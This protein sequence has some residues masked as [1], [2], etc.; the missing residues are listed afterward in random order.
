MPCT[1]RRLAR[2]LW[3]CC[4]VQQRRHT[5]SYVNGTLQHRLRVGEPGASLLF[6]EMGLSHCAHDYSSWLCL[7]EC[8]C[9]HD[10]NYPFVTIHIPLHK[11]SPVPCLASEQNLV[12]SC[13]KLRKYLLCCTICRFVK[14]I[15]T[16]DHKILK[17]MA[18]ASWSCWG[19]LH[20]TFC[21]DIQYFHHTYTCAWVSYYLSYVCLTPVCIPLV[22]ILCTQTKACPFY[23]VDCGGGGTLPSFQSW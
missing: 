16:R 23:T 13:C 19:V 7:L 5:T 14:S 1:W 20:A 9:A 21:L 12:Q 10:V 3:Y 11:T 15:L 4:H 8:E 17:Y 22:P 2:A 6:S 18:T